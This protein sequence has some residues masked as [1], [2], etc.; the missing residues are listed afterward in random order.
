M[1]AEFENGDGTY[2]SR[3]YVKELRTVRGR[4]YYEA[5]VGE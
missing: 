4:D 5:I 3:K 2:I 1:L